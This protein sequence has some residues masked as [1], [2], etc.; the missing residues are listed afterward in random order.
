MKEFFTQNGNVDLFIREWGDPDADETVVLIHG[1]PDTHAVWTSVAERLAK[2]FRVVAYDVR[3]AG[4]SSAPRP[5]HYY[6][7][8]ALASDFAAV[9]DAV[10]P[11]KPVHLVGHDWG[12][13]QAWDFFS[14]ARLARRIKS[15]T[16][17]S[18]PGFSQ[19]AAGLRKRIAG[20]KADDLKSALVQLGRSWYILAFQLPVLPPLFWKTGLGDGMARRLARQGMGERAP[21]FA[22]D[23]AQGIALYRANFIP[24]MLHPKPAIVEAPV[25]LIVPTRDAFV[26]A[27]LLETLRDWAP[28]LVV[29][30]ISA[31]HWVQETHPDELARWIGEFIERTR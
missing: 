31:G 19:V 17:I 28:N 22:K 8:K 30:E 10:S 1:Y 2:R 12:S 26:G 5:T 11:T 25:Q 9:L 15:F 14:D 27:S 13:I 3:G 24:Q 21:S 23:G 29:H 16:S 6:R 18:G 4:R 20:R 7:L